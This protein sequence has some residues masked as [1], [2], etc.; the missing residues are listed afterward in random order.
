MVKII[1]ILILVML[2]LYATSNQYLPILIDNSNYKI[3]VNS[4]GSLAFSD[5]FTDA[6]PFNS[7]GMAPVSLDGETWIFVNYKGQKI[8]KKTFDSIDEFASNGLAAASK[9]GQYGYIDINGQWIIKPKFDEAYKF[10]TVDNNVSLAMAWIDE[11]HGYINQKGEWIIKPIFG[12]HY[13]TGFENEVAMVSPVNSSLYGLIDTKGKWILKPQYE[14]DTAGDIQIYKG[15][16]TLMKNGKWGVINA[17][18]KW[19][20]EPKYEYI[21][22]AEK[23]G[24]IV[25][26]NNKKIFIPLKEKCELKTN[27]T[28]IVKNNK[29]LSA[30]LIK[31]DNCDEFLKQA[32]QKFHNLK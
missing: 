22:S 31:T 32:K 3:Y 7:N 30:L 9:N 20:I 21:L 23:N 1:L 18:G 29:V 19:I 27:K 10:D 24:Y 6:L 12:S 4:D 26:R 14:W 25:E 5:C 8:N 11:K 13:D 15:H 2:N 16:F 28:E 17:Q